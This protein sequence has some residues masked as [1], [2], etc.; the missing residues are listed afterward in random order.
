MRKAASIVAQ[1]E[2]DTFG[3]IRRGM[4]EIEIMRLFRT[5]VAEL[6]GENVTFLWVVSSGT[7]FV[8]QPTE[9][10]IQPGDI[11][12][13]DSGVRYRGYASD[14]SRSA[15]LGEPSAEVEEFYQWLMDLRRS[16][17]DK[18]RAGNMPQDVLEVCLDIVQRRGIE[19]NA[20]GR[21]GHGVGLES[22]EYP[23]I[24]KEENINLEPGMVFTCNPNFL[25][26]F[27]WL[28]SEDEWLI[29][30]GE[31]ELLSAPI[32]SDHLTTIPVD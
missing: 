12:T 31:P 15:A 5:R 26:E 24:A 22:T 25:K 4:T 27:G 28:N 2:L 21:I 17:I 8:A 30:D 19:L 9:Y 16:C 3:Q 32:A 6:G 14:I 13:I 29:T 7:G 11:V 18:L 23:S 10:R 1:A 20:V